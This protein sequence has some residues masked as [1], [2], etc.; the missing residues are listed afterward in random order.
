MSQVHIDFHCR[1]AQVFLSQARPWSLET[2]PQ[3]LQQEPARIRGQSA[4]SPDVARGGQWLGKTSAD[5]RA[6]SN[7]QIRSSPDTIR[8][9]YSGDIALE[10][11][12][13]TAL[14]TVHTQ[15]IAAA[16]GADRNES[17]GDSQDGSTLGSRV[18]WRHGLASGLHSDFAI[19]D[20]AQDD[21]VTLRFNDRTSLSPQKSPFRPA[22]PSSAPP[23][24]S[25]PLPPSPKAIEVRRDDAKR[26]V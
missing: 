22:A 9:R 2:D 8:P 26:L 24:H 5:R 10:M 20:R 4:H 23:S 18:T 21:S 11:S 14:P 6:Q 7:K 1:A 13:F 25:P 12:D 3:V 16:G 17:A 19:S 15:W